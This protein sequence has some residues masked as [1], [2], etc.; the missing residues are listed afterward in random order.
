MKTIQTENGTYV[1]VTEAEK[2]AIDKKWDYLEAIEQERILLAKQAG[3][4][5]STT[6]YYT[7]WDN[8]STTVDA[9]KYKPDFYRYAFATIPWKLS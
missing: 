3:V 1:E 5:N 7:W 4:Y 2:V 6:K 9:D 8:E